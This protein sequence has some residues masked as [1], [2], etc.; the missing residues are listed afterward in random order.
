LKARFTASI[1]CMPSL[2]KLATLGTRYYDRQILKLFST[3]SLC[4]FGTKE[5]MLDCKERTADIGVVG[6]LP[7][8]ERDFPYWVGAGFIGDASVGYE[9]VDGSEMGFGL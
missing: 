6:F 2:S 9:D 4:F 5:E 8:L 3:G 7:Q 1:L